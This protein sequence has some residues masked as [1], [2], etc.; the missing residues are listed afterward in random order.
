MNEIYWIT[1]LGGLDTLFSVFWTVPLFIIIA[2]AVCFVPFGD[3]WNDDFK[4]TINKYV[5]RIVPIAII[6]LI[7]DIFT[8]STKEALLIYGLG[9]TI[10]CIKSNDKAKQIPDKAIEA[11]TKYVE[12]LDKEKKDK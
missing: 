2:Y 6:G 3:A 9:T 8:P 12:T 4:N 7:G 10:D 5:K 1:C 11:L